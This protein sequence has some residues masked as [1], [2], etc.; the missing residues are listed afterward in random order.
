MLRNAATNNVVKR[1]GDILFLLKWRCGTAGV[2]YNN[3]DLRAARLCGNVMAKKQAAT[4]WAAACQ[5]G[6]A[7]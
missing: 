3:H 4:S 2:E 6:A 1:A 5:V 7:F